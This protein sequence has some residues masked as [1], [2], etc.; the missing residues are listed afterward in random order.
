LLDFGV[1][2]SGCGFGFRNQTAN[3]L[4]IAQLDLGLRTGVGEELPPHQLIRQ[5]RAETP[6]L[7]SIESLARVESVAGMQQKPLITSERSSQ[8]GRA[9]ACG[10]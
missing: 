1:G 9:R 3:H 4:E 10:S 7:G 6:E 8:R 5:L 2:L